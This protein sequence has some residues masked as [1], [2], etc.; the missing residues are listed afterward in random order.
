MKIALSCCLWLAACLAAAAQ[1]PV[2]STSAR[3]MERTLNGNTLS[4]PHTPR[5][6][7]TFDP[8]FR[9]AGGQRFVL[10]GIADAEQHIFVDADA[11]GNVK[12]MFWVQF[13]GFLPNHDETYNYQA[14]RT[15]RIGDFDFMVDTEPFGHPDNAASDGGHV[16]TLLK[17]KGFH[18]PAN[19]VRTKLLYLPDSNRRHELM[20]IYVEDGKTAQVSPGDMASADQVRWKPIEERFI[21][22]IQKL[23]QARR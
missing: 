21:A 4:S 14:K 8:A 6:D 17:A 2:H 5:I 20:I 19:G 15:A 10:L 16:R 11:S 23:M 9:Y 7:L 18:W 12:R 3:P 13:E 22:H 1:Q